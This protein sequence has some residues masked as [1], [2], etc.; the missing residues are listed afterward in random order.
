M[1]VRA[2]VRTPD[3]K[4]ADTIQK[5]ADK[6]GCKADKESKSQTDKSQKAKA[7]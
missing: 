5:A 1:D 2:T 6:G 4:E 3:T 7:V